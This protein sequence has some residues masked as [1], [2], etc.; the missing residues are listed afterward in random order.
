MFLS[1]KLLF[2]FLL[3]RVKF[4][5]EKDAALFALKVSLFR[6]KRAV[7][8]YFGFIVRQEKWWCKFSA[9]IVPIGIGWGPPS[10]LQTLCQYNPLPEAQLECV[11]MGN[12]GDE[13]SDEVLRR[14]R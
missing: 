2:V 6:W 12:L 13:W 7:T 5:T 4:S 1:I 3:I 8:I 14:T 11:A 9:H 10:S